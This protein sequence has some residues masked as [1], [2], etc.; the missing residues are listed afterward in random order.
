[1]NL[2]LITFW[3]G[4]GGGKVLQSVGELDLENYTSNNQYLLRHPDKNPGTD[5]AFCTSMMQQ[6]N[7]AKAHVDNFFIN[8][9]SGAGATPAPS[10]GDSGG[11]G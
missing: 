5:A 11:G 10:D 1:M 9:P 8:G 2:L 4:K 6:I 7:D 3:E